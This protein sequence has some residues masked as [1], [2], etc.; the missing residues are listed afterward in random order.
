M[1]ILVTGG[2]G[3][4]GSH[5]AV[6]LLASGHDVV[7]LDDLSNASEEAVRRIEQVSGRSVRFVRGDAADRSCL[8]QIFRATQI[9]GVIHF[10]GFKAVGE[11]TEQPL[12]YYR[13]N[14]GTAITLTEAMTAHGVKRLIFSSSATVYGAIDK[15]QYVET[16]QTGVGIVNPYGRT[17]YMV[18]EI[19]KDLCASDGSWAIT[20]LRY[21][22]PIGAHESGLMGEDPDGIPNNLMP[23]VA[24]VAVGK[25]DKLRVF[26]NDYDTPDGTCQRDFID[27]MDLARGHVSAM[28][29]MQAGTTM[30]V[31]NLGTGR[32]VSVLE[33][34]HAFEKAAGHTI[35]FEYAPRRAGDLPCYY[36]D[37]SKA[38]RELDWT[39]DISVSDSCAN[40]WKWQSRNPNGYE[41]RALTASKLVARS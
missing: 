11:S 29:R 9:D 27:V 10:A 1:T 31:Y 14:L 37:P 21:F 17:K 32:P 2:A 39:A 40:V 26:G 7:I 38:K 12:K 36:A 33:L 4:I 23:Y 18:E 13:N 6:E 20:A 35:P 22:N 30:Q 34:V 3:Y 16:D 8:D 15:V 41:T 5:T 28:T 24:Q 19:L 25:L